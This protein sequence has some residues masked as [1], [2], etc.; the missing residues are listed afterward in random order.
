MSDAPKPQSVKSGEMPSNAAEVSL[1][2][3][4]VDLPGQRLAFAWAIAAGLGALSISAIPSVG[5]IRFLLPVGI[6]VGYAWF[7]YPRHSPSAIAT[8]LRSAR[9]AQ[10]ADSLYFLGFLWTLWALIDSFV[11]REGRLPEDVFRVFGYA[12]I[13]TASGMGFR[14][15]LLQFKYGPGDQ[16]GEAQ[17]TVEQQLQKF[18][19]AMAT[20]VDSLGEFRAGALEALGEFMSLS[21]QLN[22]RVEVLS[23]RAA[24]LD[25]TFAEIH[26]QTL[27]EVSSSIRLAVDEVRTA[28]KSP[29]QEYGRAVRAFTARVNQQAQLLEE[30]V[31]AGATS[32]QN[33]IDAEVPAVRQTIRGAGDAI[34]KDSGALISGLRLKVAQVAEELQTLAERIR[35]VH[36]PTNELSSIAAL[37]EAIVRVGEDFKALASVLGEKGD[38]R[39]NLHF[40]AEQT[41]AAGNEVA[42][43]L[44][45]L[46]G[47][48]ISIDV[49]QQVAIDLAGLKGSADELQ[50]AL[51]NLAQKAADPKWN[52]AFG[53]VVG[54]I[55]RLSKAASGLRGKLEVATG[56]QD[57][58]SGRKDGDPNERT[59]NR[60]FWE[61]LGRKF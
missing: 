42:E 6:M 15:Y 22:Q 36:L 59:H 35:Q 26:R 44:E 24:E 37:S 9:I 8:P 55:E 19:Y 1:R 20:A 5:L 43:A 16:A 47:R 25:R 28:L 34:A 32:I 7:A 2:R 57:R 23:N 54:E 33:A 13:T 52:E 60:S 45:I 10:L 11:L 51:G 4:R 21:T 18:S 14:L 39:K 49:P 29:V 12:L 3:W 30:I 40:L 17:L 61:W 31:H 46:A 58:P 53:N 56:I 48:I 41:L 27:A 38:L 50:L